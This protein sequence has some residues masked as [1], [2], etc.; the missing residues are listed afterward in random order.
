MKH[1]FM[2]DTTGMTPAAPMTDTDP[3]SLHT[4]A[5]LEGHTETS[6]LVAE[7]M[8]RYVI[9][10]IN[11]N[12]YGITTDATVELMDSDT[13]QITRVSHTPSFVRGVINHRGSIIPV[14]SMR[15]MLGFKACVE[16]IGESETT[17]A[18]TSMMVITEFGAQK[19]GLIV[20]R[21]HSV[22]D[23]ADD[24]VQPLP[25]STE[26]ATFLKGLVHQSDGSYILIAN[27]EHIYQRAC[28]K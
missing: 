25:E 5:H 18:D 10:E 3:F 7:N 28:P 15:T 1:G 14:I 9:V 22:F 19:I 27:I 8:T 21:V 13:I 23:C 16:T 4:K 20:D 26:N 24:K 12:M 17:K 6:A 2:S 11:S